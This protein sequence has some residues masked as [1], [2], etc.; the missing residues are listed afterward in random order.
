M[1]VK[2]KNKRKIMNN[3]SVWIH[4]IMVIFQ[5]PIAEAFRAD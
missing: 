4:F 5:D 2:C 3:L 1:K